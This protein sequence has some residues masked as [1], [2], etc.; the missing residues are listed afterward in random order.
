MPPLFA[1]FDS[2]RRENVVATS[3]TGTPCHVDVYKLRL[4]LRRPL[5]YRD[6][7]GDPACGARGGVGWGIVPQEPG[8]AFAR[9]IGAGEEQYSGAWERRH[10][11]R[12]ASGGAAHG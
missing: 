12:K 8:I 7:A 1:S 6:S 11:L 9:K 10:D 2:G 3:R 4:V 5:R